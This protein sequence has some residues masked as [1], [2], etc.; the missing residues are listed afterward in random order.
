VNDPMK[1][2]DG[3]RDP[4]AA[5]ALRANMEIHGKAL[6]DLGRSVRIMEVCGSHTMAIARFG[7]REILPPCIDLVS[8]PGCPVCVTPP[9][10]VDAAIELAGRGLTVATFGDMINVPGSDSSLAESRADGAA[11]EVCYSPTRTLELAADSPDREFVF[12]AI[13]FETTIAPVISIVKQAISKGIKNVSLL[14]AFKVVP[15]AL[16]VLLGDPELSVDALLCPAHVS[17]IIGSDA[18]IPIVENYNKTCIVAGF[19][20]LDILMGIDRILEL[21]IEDRAAC[22]NQYSRVVTPEGNRIAQQVMTDMLE[23]CDP[24]WRGI[25]VIPGSGLKLRDEFIA[26]DAADKFEITIGPGR[27]HAG[28]LCGGVIKGSHKPDQCAF[29]GKE[30]TPDSPIGPCMVSSEGTCA[31][32]YKY[33]RA[34]Q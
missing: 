32:Y 25:G 6:A 22:E 8:G 10:Y 7:V 18:Y 33:L 1:W 23:S 34:T 30:C 21:A 3:F 28:C 20:P 27:E 26:Y 11:I 12:L 5:L 29:F 31:A 17:A 2:I 15:P 24:Y 4:A 13:G 9:G 19:E 14:T 16:D